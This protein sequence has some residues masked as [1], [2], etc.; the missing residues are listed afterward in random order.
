MHRADEHRPPVPVEGD[1]D[2]YEVYDD[3]AVVDAQS[4]DL[5]CLL[6][7]PMNRR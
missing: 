4:T 6:R 7:V 5:L 1:Y 3:E 2:L